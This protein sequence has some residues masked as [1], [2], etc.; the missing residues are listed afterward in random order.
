FKP[1]DSE[2]GGKDALIADC[3]PCGYDTS[4]WGLHPD[5]AAAAWTNM[6][7]P[8]N[9]RSLVQFDLSSIPPSAQITS[10]LLSLFHNPTP[11]SAPGH[12]QLSGPN[13][14]LLQRITSTWDEMTV[15][16]NTQPTTTTQ[17]QVTLPPSTSA[18]QDYTNIDVTALV[19]DM[20]NN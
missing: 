8:S 2:C 10:A 11:A 19:Q 14:A 4:N 1:D 17:N 5:F 20:V 12:S 15:T 6:G 7:N 16:W 13:D 9:E 3:V 18:T